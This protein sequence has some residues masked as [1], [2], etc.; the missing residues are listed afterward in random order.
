MLLRGQR[1]GHVRT[2]VERALVGDHR[3]AARGRLG[4]LDGVLDGLGAAVEERG[5][6][7]PADG[8]PLAQL[9]GELDVGVVRHDREVGVEEAR[10]LCLDG[11]RDGGVRVPDGKAADA[12]GEVDERVAVDVG[13]ERAL[14]ALDEDRHPQAPSRSRRR[15][16]CARSRRASAVRGSRYGSRSTACTER[17][18]LHRPHSPSSD[19][20]GR[21][22][23]MTEN[24]PPA[25]SSSRAQRPGPMSSGSCQTVPPSSRQRRAVPSQSAVA[26]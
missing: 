17:S 8:Q 12:A 24:V 11:A 9:L 22:S 13:D 20:S 1:H 10:D 5:L 19:H 2:A 18:A 4:D 23:V 7:R 26:M 15:A 6:R 16:P 21:R 25:G 3:R 14:G